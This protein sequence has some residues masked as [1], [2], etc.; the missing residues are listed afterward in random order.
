MGLGL[1]VHLCF[2]EG[3]KF[4]LG[5][6]IAPPMA[7]ASVATST[8]MPAAVSTTMLAAVSTTT[9]AISTTV[10]TIAR[11]VSTAVVLCL[12]SFLIYNFLC[13]SET[14]AT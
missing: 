5:A 1:S 4:S 9:P 11:A 2:G 6:T 8:T 7:T 12:C 14:S 3:V 13:H 10:P